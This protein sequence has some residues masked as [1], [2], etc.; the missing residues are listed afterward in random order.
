MGYG[1]SPSHN[2]HLSVILITGAAVGNNRIERSMTYFTNF[3]DLLKYRD[4]QLVLLRK[5][6][7]TRSLFGTR[8][9]RAGKEFNEM[10][11][12][13]RSYAGGR[14]KSEEARNW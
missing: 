4:E 9:R 8:V 2:A 12:R 13:G 5:G 10:L 1:G 11:D 3:D 6:K 14:E 7:I